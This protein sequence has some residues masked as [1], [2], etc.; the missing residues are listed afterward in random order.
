[1]TDQP[2]DDRKHDGKAG[3]SPIRRFDHPDLSVTPGSR[4]LQGCVADPFERRR[5]MQWNR[6]IGGFPVDQD[7][8]AV[9]PSSFDVIHVVVYDEA[10]DGMDQLPIADIREE[11]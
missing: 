3:S 2:L 5:M 8:I 6:D 11:I 9:D 4:G 7:A 10:I 1:M